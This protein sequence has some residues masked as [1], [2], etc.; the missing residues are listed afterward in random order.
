MCAFLGLEH[1]FGVEAEQF[2]KDVAGETRGSS[3][4]APA[5]KKKVR[6]KDQQC[7]EDMRKAFERRRNLIV[8][9]VKEIPGLEVNVP[10]GAFY[11]FPRSRFPGR[12][13]GRK[14]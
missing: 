5:K 11:V 10:D 1:L 13:S 8:D 9:L 12:P 14:S 4:M 6:A 2:G 3:R 7:V